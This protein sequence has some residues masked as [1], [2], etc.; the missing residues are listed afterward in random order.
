MAVRPAKT[1]SGQPKP[2]WWEIDCYPQGRK[3][4]RLQKQIRCTHAEALEI[5]R[6]LRQMRRDTPPVNP[7]IA[8]VVPDYLEW[9]SLHRSPV[10]VRDFQG[11]LK[12]LLPVF[13]SHPVN[14]I[15]QAHILQFQRDRIAT[16]QAVEDR[17]AL[18]AERQPRKAHPARA[19][20]KELDYLKGL[21]RWMVERSM[22]QPLGFK[23]DRLPYERPLPEVPNVDDV[24]ALLAQINDPLKLAM[25]WIMFEGGTR[26][27]ETAAL[28]WEDVD[29]QRETILLRQKTKRGKL[30]AVVLPQEAAALLRPIW[31]E[32]NKAAKGRAPAGE[33][34]VNPKTGAPYTSLKTMLAGA[35]RRAGIK[36]ISPHK[37]RHAFA[38]HL[39]SA[40]GDLRLV[41]TA[42]GH[43]DL[44]TTTIYTQVN[45]DRLRDGLT[46]SRALRSD[47]AKGKTKGKQAVA[48][49]D[50][51]S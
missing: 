46:K 3:G 43:Q 26:Y 1:R 4:P 48:N 24:A 44:R 21:L 19:V 12:H 14:R 30:R 47:L 17:R 50:S 42:L 45:L 13:G 5:E 36:R 6:G 28:R 2:G 10:T 9:M 7:R 11:A 37:L 39:L 34:F 22:A 8:E 41:Q 40:T 38:T 33:I 31:E 51:D 16:A 25:L 15:T 35:A 49:H 29:L 32:R 18:A 27:G 20:N 23:I